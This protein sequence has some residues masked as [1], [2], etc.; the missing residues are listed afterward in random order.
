MCYFCV[1]SQISKTVIRWFEHDNHAFVHAMYRL[2]IILEHDLILVCLTKR[3]FCFHYV[4]GIIFLRSSRFIISS[5]YFMVLSI[6]CSLMIA[7]FLV[8]SFISNFHVLL[9]LILWIYSLLLV[10]W[11]KICLEC[12]YLQNHQLR[13]RNE[14]KNCFRVN[15]TW[16]W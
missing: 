8:C 5:F 6:F 4:L 9:L 11:N 1:D 16:I 12:L 3:C 13:K 2:R 10:N 7:W 14:R 15:H